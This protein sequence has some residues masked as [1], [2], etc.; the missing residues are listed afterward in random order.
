MMVAVAVLVSFLK[1]RNIKI[2]RQEFAIL[3][4]WWSVV[5]GRCDGSQKI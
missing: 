3:H 4:C 5:L 2:S 1:A